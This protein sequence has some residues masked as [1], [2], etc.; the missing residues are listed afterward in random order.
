VLLLIRWNSAK[1]FD[2]CE[3]CFA[4]NAFKEADDE[5]LFLNIIFRVYT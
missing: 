2:C 1:R 3:S 5:F 4:V